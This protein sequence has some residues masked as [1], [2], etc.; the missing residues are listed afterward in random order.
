MPQRLPRLPR[1]LSPRGA[2]LLLLGVTL[3][4]LLGAWRFLRE[5]APESPHTIPSRLAQFGP[6][7]DRR[8]RPLWEAAGEAYPP[9]HLLFVAYKAERRLDLYH[10]TPGAV[11]HPLRALAPDARR[12]FIKSYPILGASGE[13]GPKL[14]EG[15]RQVPEGFYGIGYLNP[16][17]RFHLSMQIDY[18]NADDRAQAKADGRT[19]L[20]GDIM[21]HGGS[22]SIGCLA[23]GDPVA[24]EL[25][26]LAARA[27]VENVEVVVSPVDFRRPA[28]EL[29]GI[30]TPAT[31]P[32]WVQRRHEQLREALKRL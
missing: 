8:L 26:V 30:Y 15:D 20:G 24:E 31:F 4:G 23:M 17:S 16:N 29:D 25:F 1:L 27:G 2:A 21:I 18:P 11:A 3:G 14:R 9:A 5:R 6:A 22:A 12:R 28:A 13:P 7:V 10:V 32:E 19:T